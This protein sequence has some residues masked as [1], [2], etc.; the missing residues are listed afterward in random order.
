MV[1]LVFEDLKFEED[2]DRIRVRFLD[3][4][5]F[6]VDK[7]EFEN[8][9]KFTVKNNTVT[10]HDLSKS[11]ASGKLSRV[12]DRGFENLISEVTRKKTVYVNKYFGLP[13]IG[14]GAFGIV[15]RNSSMLEI[16][17]LTGC[18]MNCIFCSVDEGLTSKKSTDIIIDKDYLVE[19]AKKIVDLKGCE[20]QITINAQGEPT[21]YK[22]MPELIE[23]LIN[24]K[25][26]KSVSLIT[27]G[28]LLTKDYID[29]L[30]K[31]RLTTLNVSLNAISDRVGKTLEGTGKYDVEHVKKMCR[32]ASKKLLVILAPVYVPGYSEQELEKI[33]K[34][35][36]EIGAEV[37]VQN[38]LYYQQGRNPNGV[39]QMEWDLFYKMLRDLEKK[40]EIRLIIDEN[41]FGITKTKP[42]PKPF[43]KNHI[44]DAEIKCLGRYGNEVIAAAQERN[45]TVTD[46]KKTTGR[47]RI[48]IISDKHNIYYGKVS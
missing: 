25:K 10:F 18:N 35:A 4:F 22:P 21:M 36:K 46:C 28:T 32:Y 37:G 1:E 3:N 26:V 29:R 45:I 33:I 41:D 6:D 38:F 34:F 16:K 11:D 14:S 39:K 44:V 17:P 42:L 40:H 43:R 24:I 48:K 9:S 30:A 27:N 7:K 31:A 13:L 2:K 20:V 19:E 23:D 5:Y 15:D 12:I 8:I 47:V